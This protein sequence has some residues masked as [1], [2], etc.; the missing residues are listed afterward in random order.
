MDAG[1]VQ[2]VA[3]A[4]LDV[5]LANG[6]KNTDVFCAALA[7]ILRQTH[8]A[9]A[10][11]G[12]CMSAA[13][14]A[15]HTGCSH[16]C[17]QPGAGAWISKSLAAIQSVLRL[18]SKITCLSVPTTSGRSAKIAVLTS[19]QTSNAERHGAMLSMMIM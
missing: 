7:C 17:E 14:N 13:W 9:P 10:A 18:A 3:G 4:G 15:K 16:H 11:G 6:F 19:K 12:L 8:L 2:F 1:K 5:R